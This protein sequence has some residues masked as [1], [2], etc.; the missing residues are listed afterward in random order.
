[1]QDQSS[2]TL[3]D[4]SPIPALYEQ[5]ATED[6]K[7]SKRK[8]GNWAEGTCSICG[9]DTEVMRAGALL[10]QTFGS[11]QEL[12]R[13]NTVSAVCK[14]CGW[15][16]KDKRLLYHP[17]W[18]QSGTGESLSWSELATRLA[19]RDVDAS[20]SVIAPTSGRKIVA[21][22]A[23][24]GKVITDH[25][26]LTW[27]SQYRKALQVCIN[28]NKIGMRGSLLSQEVPPQGLLLPVDP[29]KHRAVHEMWDYLAFVREDKTLLALFAKITMNLKEKEKG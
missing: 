24:Y 25:G 12:S 1:M 7:P 20:V 3:L 21:P 28:L 13:F 16:L 18:V 10:G 4:T 5:M 14:P 17:T 2:T 23:R 8:K 27:G 29:Q 6:V 11:W 19:T 26:A 15:A 9:D 22:Y